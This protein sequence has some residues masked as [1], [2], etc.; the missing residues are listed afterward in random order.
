MHLPRGP[1]A[2]P[3]FFNPNLST[4]YIPKKFP[5]SEFLYDV[6]KK[7][8]IPVNAAG[9]LKDPS[10]SLPKPITEHFELIR[11]ASPPELPPAVLEMS[12]GFFTFPYTLFPDSMVERQTAILDLVIG[13]APLFLRISTIRES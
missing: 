7:V 2:L 5:Q 11:Q 1:K 10:K 8:Y 6:G 12:Q 3:N 4:V 13:I 9:I